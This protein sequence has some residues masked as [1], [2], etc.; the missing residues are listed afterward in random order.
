MGYVGALVGVQGSDFIK[1]RE[2]GACC[3]DTKVCEWLSVLNQY[4]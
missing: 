1:V 2:A 4:C 3:A